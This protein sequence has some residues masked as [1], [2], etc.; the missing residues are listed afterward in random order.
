MMTKDEE[1]PYKVKKN[2]KSNDRKKYEHIDNDS[3][4]SVSFFSEV[5]V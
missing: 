5:R 3:S 1:S 4:L 2:Y